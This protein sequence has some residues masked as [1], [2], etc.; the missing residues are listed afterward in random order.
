M[1][2]ET[3]S[4]HPGAMLADAVRARGRGAA[5]QEA[6]V[7]AVRR[8]RDQARAAGRWLRWLRLALAV[9]REKR[10]LARLRLF[11]RFPTDKEASIQAGHDAERRVAE[12][13]GSLLDDD[14]ILFRGYRN[15]RG[16]IDGLLVG[17]RGLFAY[18]VKY[19]NATVYVRGDGWWSEK[20]DRYGNSLGG[21]APMAD[22]R[23]RSP[24]AQISDPA[25]A[26]SD[27]LRRRGQQATVTP[28]VLL[29]HDRTRVGSSQR[30]T[31]RVE[32]SV[33]GVLRLIEQSAVTLDARRRAVIEQIIRDDHR[34]NEQRL[35]RPGRAHN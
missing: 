1:R 30:P 21:P 28:V 33:Q 32:T 4:D 22:A 34:H 16:E 29:T 25:V 9:S 10:E 11:S 31:V 15:R 19:H 18:E 6:R 26:L 27:W 17:P 20:F 14:W 12:E 5:E 35:S 8:D 3:L 13:L 2:A 23:G 24:S 7:E